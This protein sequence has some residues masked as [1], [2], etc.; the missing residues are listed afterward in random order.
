MW[1]SYT[2][3]HEIWGENHLFFSVKTM[4]TPE[5]YFT[6]RNVTERQ[7][8]IRPVKKRSFDLFSLDRMATP[9]DLFNILNK[10]LTVSGGW[11]LCRWKPTSRRYSIPALTSVWCTPVREDRRWWPS[12]A[13][14]CCALL[15]IVNHFRENHP[16]KQTLTRISGV[17]LPYQIS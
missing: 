2:I 1:C 5:A 6:S 17:K 15:G 3:V 13:K 8:H 10:P 12:T 14:W 11:S 9:G 4:L 16:C 7:L